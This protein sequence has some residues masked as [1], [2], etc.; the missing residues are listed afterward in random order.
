MKILVTGGTAFVSAY[1][2]QHYVTLGHEVYVLNRGTKTQIEG[3]HLLKFDRHESFDLSHYN[4]DTV[5]DVT[6]YTGEDVMLLL[7][8]L[9]LECLKN[10][11]LISSSA[12]YGQDDK[13]PFSENLTPK[14]NRIWKDYG[15]HKIAAEKALQDGFRHYYI[16][17]PPYLYGPGNN[18]YRE[19]FVFDCALMDRPFYVPAD[20][21]M[22]LQFFYIKDLARMIDVLLQKQPKERIFNVG[23][24]VS[25]S[26]NEW[27]ELCYEV[28]QK[29]VQLI[30]VD[31]K[32]NYRSYFPFYD[33]EYHL[34]T[35]LQNCYLR[36]QTNLKDGLKS[37]LT[38]YLS[39]K[40]SV[41]QRPYLAFI[42]EQL[43]NAND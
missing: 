10:Y 5:I 37:S 29:Q 31:P 28:C 18:V 25:V 20:G 15:I 9:N 41:N 16:I 36:E 34:Q 1:L 33:Y 14:P 17:R 26:I 38:W 32:I 13:Q 23:N 19:A 43:E 35:D 8:A 4:F 21:K 39:H 22:Q 6:A 27:V 11:I 30:N 12:V 40:G 42:K 2:A 3:V 7:Q 24:D